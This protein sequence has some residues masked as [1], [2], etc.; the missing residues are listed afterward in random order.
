M[1]GRLILLSLLLFSLPLFANAAFV[2]NQDANTDAFITEFGHANDYA[3]AFVWPQEDVYSWAN[4]PEDDPATLDCDFGNATHVVIFDDVAALA[5]ETG[6]GVATGA[7]LDWVQSGSVPGA[8]SGNGTLPTYR[9]LDDSASQKFSFS[10]ALQNMFKNATD[11]LWMFKGSD[12]AT[13]G[14]AILINWDGQAGLSNF[15]ARRHAGGG[16][17]VVAPGLASG[18][19]TDAIDPDADEVYIAIWRKNGGATRAGF[20]VG[21]KITS[22]AGIPANQRRTGAGSDF[23]LA[24]TTAGIL[25]QRA[26]AEYFKVKAHFLIIST[27][28]RDIDKF[29]TD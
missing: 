6:T 11:W 22:W 15:G 13:S 17:E 5:N 18:N 28:A 2:R 20:K 9:Q 16:L 29:I 21:E 8:V 26:G 10:V 12:L 14:N 27:G 25:G 19:T 1:R 24:A 4:W 3:D 7:D 23:N